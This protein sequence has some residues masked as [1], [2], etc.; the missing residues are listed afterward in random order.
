MFTNG[1]SIKLEVN[2]DES[3]WQHAVNIYDLFNFVLQFYN[4]IYS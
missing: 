3:N 1:K 4:F 2:I